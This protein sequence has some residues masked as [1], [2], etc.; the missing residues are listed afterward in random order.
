[1][2]KTFTAPLIDPNMHLKIKA[3][4]QQNIMNIA[5]Q[6]F[7]NKYPE[8]TTEQC[9]LLATEHVNALEKLSND[10]LSNNT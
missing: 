7:I 2:G 10:S 3:M 1:M 4:K 8:F 9:F 5:T 6:L